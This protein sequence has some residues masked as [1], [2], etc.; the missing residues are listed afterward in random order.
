[1]ALEL[2][3]TVDEAR[4]WVG[5]SQRRGGRLALVPTM[6]YLHQGHLAL[7]R[8]GKRA[9]DRVAA[10]IF[11]NP[12]QFGPNDDLSRYPRD[13]DG[14]LKKCR[15][16]GVEAVFAPDAAELYP[17]GFQT[18]VEVGEISRGLC[19]EK[20]P[21][22][23]RGVATVVAKL[24]CLF[25]PHVAVFGEKDYQQLQ[26]IRRLNLDLNLGSEILSVPTVR[27]RDGLAMSS[28]NAYLSQGERRRALSI[29][30]GLRRA[31]E[32]VMTGVKDARELANAMREE[33]ERAQLREDYVAIVDAETLAPLERISAER[34]ARALIAAFVGSTRLIDNLP[35]DA[36]SA[37]GSSQAQG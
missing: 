20:R 37:D 24:L 14:D 7:I 23:F 29:F 6:G 21:G 11:V 17:P 26:V 16:A 8:E 25:R 10:T 30:A 33:L 32:R 34:P 15:D 3:R 5:L 19:G 27:D 9:A 36:R 18:F 12:T 31:Q 35:L 2:L 22:H 28:R 13:M 1:M 4:R